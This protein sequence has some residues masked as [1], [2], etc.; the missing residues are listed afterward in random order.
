[1]LCSKLYCKKVFNLITFPCKVEG[2]RERGGEG[3]WDS[4]EEGERE[5]GG[6]LDVA[7]TEISAELLAHAVRPLFPNAL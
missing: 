4:W 6:A 5:E 3:G 2:E 7:L 1:M